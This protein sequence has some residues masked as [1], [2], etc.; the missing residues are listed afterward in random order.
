[1]VLLGH[2]ELNLFYELLRRPGESYGH[3][4]SVPEHHGHAVPGANHMS[5]AQCKT[6]VTPVR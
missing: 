6:A 1:M 4:G 3:I 2:T 5:R